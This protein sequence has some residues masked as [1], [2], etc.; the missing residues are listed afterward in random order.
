MS[1]IL[2]P[3]LGEDVQ[4][5]AWNWRPTVEFLRAQNV[6]TSDHAELLTCHGTDARVDADLANR[7]T[8]AVEDKLSAMKSGERLR[9]DL[10]VTAAPKTPAV[11]SPDM[12][13]DDIDANELYSA[14]HEWLA[15]FRDFCRRSRGFLVS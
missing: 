5:N 4:V 14:T 15:T 10:T 1:F 13:P 3:N 12:K 9:A 8:A 7:M 11:F 6:I 2:V